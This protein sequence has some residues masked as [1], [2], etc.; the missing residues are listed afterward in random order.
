MNANTSRWKCEGY[1]PQQGGQDR[2]KNLQGFGGNIPHRKRGEDIINCPERKGG[3]DGAL[4]NTSF[5]C[6][7]E[8]H[9]SWDWIENGKILM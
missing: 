6:F 2:E 7:T 4:L 3:K 5:L 1:P 9:G 8:N